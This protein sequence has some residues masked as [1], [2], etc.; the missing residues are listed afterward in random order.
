[1]SM[2]KADEFRQST[3]DFWL[4]M[5]DQKGKVAQA[6]L[7]ISSKTPSVRAS[8]SKV[9]KKTARAKKLTKRSK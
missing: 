7:P 3:K 1:M 8:L 4:K 5:D 6:T 9:H 2:S